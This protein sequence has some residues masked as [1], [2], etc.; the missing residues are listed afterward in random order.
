MKFTGSHCTAALLLVE[1]EPASLFENNGP[2]EKARTLVCSA[3]THPWFCCFSFLSPYLCV[4]SSVREAESGSRQHRTTQVWWPLF[5]FA[6]TFLALMSTWSS[7]RTSGHTNE[8][9][10]CE[11]ERELY[12]HVCRVTVHARS[13]NTWMSIYCRTDAGPVCYTHVVKHCQS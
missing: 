10:E 8:R 2:Q 7:N 9:S 5:N 13:R 6:E 1:W 4:L 12:M 3:G 11:P